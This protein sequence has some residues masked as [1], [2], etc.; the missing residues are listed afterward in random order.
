MLSCADPWMPHVSPGVF[1]TRPA[2]SSICLAHVVLVRPAYRPQATESALTGS[3]FAWAALLFWLLGSALA[4]GDLVTYSLATYSLVWLVFC[5]QLAGMAC[6]TSL[7]DSLKQGLCV[8][9]RS[10]REIR[11]G[12]R[13][14]RTGAAPATWYPFAARAKPLSFCAGWLFAGG[15]G[16]RFERQLEQERLW[17]HS[18]ADNMDSFSHSPAD[19]IS[20]HPPVRMLCNGFAALHPA[21]NH[22]RLLGGYGGPPRSFL[23]SSETCMKVLDGYMTQSYPCTQC[24]LS[25]HSCFCL[26][27]ST[28]VFRGDQVI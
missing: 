27:I 4:L 21:S 3:T 18:L 16:A 8:T 26:S 9:M 23:V 17:S 22:N 1:C 15:P 10:S 13:A 28:P 25:V 7:Q 2:P 11:K 14:V 12:L 6:G 24:A 20:R 19:K 5:C